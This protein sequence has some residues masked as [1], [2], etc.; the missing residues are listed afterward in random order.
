TLKRVEHEQAQKRD[1]R[2]EISSAKIEQR[3]QGVRGFT[4]AAFDEEPSPDQAATLVDELTA[5]M[6][7]LNERDRQI[8]E[9]R[10]QE[11]TYE[12]IATMLGISESTVRRVLRNARDD[13]FQELTND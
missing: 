5:L 8:L 13:L 10:L 11:M 7:R 6:E 3:S 4:H 1:Y 9:Y 12:E 2:S